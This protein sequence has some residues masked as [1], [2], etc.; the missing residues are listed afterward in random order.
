MANYR[1]SITIEKP[2]A[3]IRT[4]LEDLTR[5][6]SFIPDGFKSHCYVTSRQRGEGARAT[7]E[8]NLLGHWLPGEIRV[9]QSS[10][11]SV[12]FQIST[13]PT[14]L[15]MTFEL[16]PRDEGTEVRLEVR[17]KRNLLPPWRVRT[18]IKRFFRTDRDV[19]TLCSRLLAMLKETAETGSSSTPGEWQRSQDDAAI[20]PSAPD[21]Q[22]TSTGAAQETDPSHTHHA[23]EQARQPSLA[24][25]AEWIDVAQV[26]EIEPGEARVVQVGDQDVAVF[27]VGGTYHAI[28]NSCA[29]RGGSLGFGLLEDTTVT[30][31]LHGWQYDITTG[32]CHTTPGVAQPCYAVS[33]HDGWLRV[34]SN[35]KAS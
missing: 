25:I 35:P 4:L 31:P 32:A 7:L 26:D 13:A 29:H 20:A 14:D 8:L 6:P 17:Y 23:E 22:G 30:C 3:E 34:A 33:Q 21:G 19:V 24:E 5:H 15:N 18:R 28:A 16:I 27:N 1:D 10:K 2:A 11:N 12:A 9:S